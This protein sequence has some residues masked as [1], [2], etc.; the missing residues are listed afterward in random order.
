MSMLDEPAFSSDAPSPSSATREQLLAW[1]GA[2]PGRSVVLPNVHNTN[3]DWMNDSHGLRG[4]QDVGQK[5]TVQAQP[6]DFK[7][8][9]KQW[10]SAPG[11]GQ[12]TVTVEDVSGYAP[13]SG[14]GTVEGVD[15]LTFDQ[16]LFEIYD[17]GGGQCVVKLK[18]TTCT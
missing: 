11:G 1:Q 5:R 16:D 3:S 17:G 7:V 15:V 2:E 13:G 8:T 9:D 6:S 12:V 10:F 4:P 14:V 18:T